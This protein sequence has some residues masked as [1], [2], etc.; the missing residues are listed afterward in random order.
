[1]EDL[2]ELIRQRDAINGAIA[3]N[4]LEA[5]GG[6]VPVDHDM[7]RDEVRKNLSL[8]TMAFVGEAAK[9]K[10]RIATIAAIPKAQLDYPTMVE[11]HRAEKRLAEIEREATV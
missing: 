10:E 1:M 11:R 6:T 8:K 4:M 2:K 9:L 5:Q 7:F 3:K